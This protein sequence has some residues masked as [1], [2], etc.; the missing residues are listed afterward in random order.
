[1]KSK[2]IVAPAIII[3]II[4]LFAIGCKGNTVFVP[5]D[6]ATVQFIGRATCAE[7][8]SSISNAYSAQAHGQDF[9]VKFGSMD[10]IEGYGG[11]C[12][13]C[14]TTGWEEP[15]GY[16]PDGSTPYLEGIGCEECHGPGSL[17]AADPENGHI[18]KLPDSKESCWDCHVPDFHGKNYKVLDIGIGAITDLELYEV[19]PDEP[20]HHPQTAM[21]LGVLGYNRTDEPGAHAQVENTC[22][23]CHL[24]SFEEARG[25]H[26]ATSLNIDYISCDDCHA[27]E[28]IAE[29]MVENEQAQIITMLIELGGEDPENPGH[30]DE[31]ASGG[32]L[33]AYATSK[34]IVLDSNDNPDSSVVKAYK[35]AYHNFSFV[36]S[37]GSLGV[38][39]P[40]YARKLLEDAKTL[41]GG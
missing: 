16:N 27:S 20:V 37:D 11:A 33:G 31:S 40:K 22:I 5:N 21:L 6:S 26:G 14:H 1:V 9:R 35:A 10:L 13:P 34:R 23:N 17:H 36:L 39:N 2:Q 4:V 15:T 24:Y 18:T 7:C 19:T 8:H 29:A 32:L 25:H 28:E 3:T 30:P 41:I 38:H 12:A